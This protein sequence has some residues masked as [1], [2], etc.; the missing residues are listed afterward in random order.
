M[1]RSL[2]D[3]LKDRAEA[4]I[5]RWIR[6]QEK[7]KAAER[8]A[9]QDADKKGDTPKAPRRRPVALPRP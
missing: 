9:K 4:E 7:R 2:T 1:A 8:K 6:E 3:D 5:R